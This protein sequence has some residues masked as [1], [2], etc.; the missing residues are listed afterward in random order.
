MPRRAHLA[1]AR[2][3]WHIIQKENNRQATFYTGADYRRYLQALGE[4]ARKHGCRIHAWRLMTN[5]VHLL[6]APEQAQNA[7]LRI[8]YMGQ[9]H[10]QYIIR[11]YRR[12]GTLRDGRFRSCLAQD[13][14]TCLPV[15][16]ISS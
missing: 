11:T 16:G 8:E 12:S 1:V 7:G 15:T 2:I 13:E 3:R 6:V 14:S 10:V 5:H 4:Q 9:R